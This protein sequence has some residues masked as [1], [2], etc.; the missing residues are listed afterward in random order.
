M[1]CS[2][3]YEKK[4]KRK[5]IKKYNFVYKYTKYGRFEDDDRILVKSILINEVR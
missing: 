5:K 3:S 2:E 1:H 4:K